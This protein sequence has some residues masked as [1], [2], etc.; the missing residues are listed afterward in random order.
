[1]NEPVRRKGSAAAHVAAALAC[2]GL[3][4]GPACAAGAS[5][6]LGQPIEATAAARA[7]GTVFADGRGLPPGR[8]SAADGRWVYEQQCL[9]CHGPEGSGGSS[10]RLVSRAASGPGAAARPDRTIGA[11]WPYATTLFDYIRR[12]MPLDRPGSLADDEVYALTAYL[13]QLG[14]IV[15]P[16]EELNA[17]TLAAVRMPNREGFIRLD[18][19]DGPDRMG[20]P[21]RAARPAAR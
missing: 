12:A 18:R 13:L 11:Y 7:D 5:P 8:G 9:A 2:A 20:H 1:M 16:H 10:G 19:I 4:T 21:G 6:R 14:G 15:G 3:L 17:E